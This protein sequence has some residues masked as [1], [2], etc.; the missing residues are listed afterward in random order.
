MEP[1][2]LGPYRLT[3]RLGRGGMGAVYEAIDEQSGQP[4]AVK[5][6]ASH[7]ADDVGLRQRF[8]AEIATLK[9]LRAAGIVKLLAYGE[10]EGQPYFSMELVRGKSLE[11]L[12]RGGRPFSWQETVALASDI[13]RSLKV[14]HDHGIIHRDLK[15]ANLL[16]ADDP[17]AAGAAVKLADFGIA[18]LFG[19]AGYTAHGSIVG[20]AEY[21]AP[22]QA[23]GK[24]LD[25][26]A[27]LYALGLVMFTMLTGKPPFRG[28]QLT[29]IISRQ[30]REK[31][32]RVGSLVP[33]LPA[34]LD[35]LISQM[36]E[37]DPAKRP[38]SALAVGRRLTAIADADTTIVKQADHRLQPS[39]PDEPAD[40]SVVVRPQVDPAAPTNMH[41]SSQPTDQVPASSPPPQADTGSVDL[42]AATRDATRAAAAAEKRDS[43]AE[44]DSPA[45]TTDLPLPQTPE[46]LPDNT[47]A[48]TDLPTAGPAADAAASNATQEFTTP[49]S[50]QPSLLP[51]DK[52]PTRQATGRNPVA[53]ATHRDSAGGA[54]DT[55][56]DRMPANRFVTVAELD[57]V[58]DEQAARSRVRQARLQLVVVLTTI[59]L[60]SCVGYLLLKPPTADELYATIAATAQATAGDLRD[61]R[62]QI[63]RFLARFPEDSR[64]SEVAGLAQTIKL[65][66]LEKRARRRILGDRAVPAIERDYRSAMAR[67]AESPSA[68]VA[69]LE[70][71]GT[72]HPLPQEPMANQADGLSADDHALWLA[73]AQRQLERLTPLAEKEQT[74]DRRR[75][76][77]LLA[78]ADALTQKAASDPEAAARRRSLLESLIATY[79]DRPHAAN[80]VAAARQRLQ[81]D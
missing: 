45:E 51:L 41:R 7:L 52:R 2:Q 79:A 66:A 4:V 31:P 73:L 74:E 19:T 63:D 46:L 78:E 30:L 38:A 28:T 72:L 57:R 75:A 55:I 58:S 37:K 17:A 40:V 71:L 35:Q 14:A 59:A 50:E 53:D 5:I 32:P 33:G 20:T 9:P 65:D 64:H 44:M 60:A 80:A 6:L 23:A 13:V 34:E 26:R 27:D 68:A 21:M 49:E 29:E 43:H 61:V 77:A 12:I 47:A 76:D 11:Q 54:A 36:L 15:P 48:T 81:D 56:V 25:A 22:E 39:G 10:D 1:Q 8:E 42:L 70:A 3:N 18:K 16:V 24:P 69:A 62:W 67:E